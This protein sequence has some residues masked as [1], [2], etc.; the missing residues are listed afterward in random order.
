M[1]D[2]VLGEIP[3]VLFVQNDIMCSRYGLDWY[4]VKLG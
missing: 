3:Y 4:T 2:G 1:S